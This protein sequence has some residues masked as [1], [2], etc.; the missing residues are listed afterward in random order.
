MAASLQFTLSNPTPGMEEEFN[1]WYGGE[2]AEHGLATPGIVAGQRFRREALGPWPAGKHDYMMIW[3]MEDPKFA[4]EQLAAA[5][6]GEKMPISPSIDMTTVQPP[7]MWLRA[8]VRNR[9]R[10]VTDTSSRKSVVLALV[11]P[12]KDQAPAFEKAILGGTL[13]ELAD[14]PGVIQAE[15]FTL[16]EEQIRG[17][18]R[19]FAYALL[20]ELANEKTAIAAL[21]T[22]LAN[23]PHGDRDNWI[24]PVFRPLGG[25]EIATHGRATR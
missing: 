24:A 18:A 16:A 13:A 1:R 4:L 12:L 23:L 6:G 3:E 7:T 5:R 10:I 9:A 21:A 2:H 8:S 20:I 14:L 25:K 11:N 19:K 22:P 15:F 17:N